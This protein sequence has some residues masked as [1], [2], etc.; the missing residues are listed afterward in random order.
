MKILFQLFIALIP[1]IFS[2]STND[3][4]LSIRFLYLSIGVSI[5]LFAHFYKK[6]KLYYNLF[7]NQF[8]ICFFLVF[9][10]CFISSLINGLTA[11]SIYFLSKIFLLIIFLLLV[12]NFLLKNSFKDFLLPILLFSFFSSIIYFYQL[13]DQYNSIVIID[14]SWHRN[15]AFDSISGSMGN[16]NLLAS[17]HFLILPFI[18]YSIRK[19][20]KFFKYFS[21]VCLFFSL[22]I[23]FQTQ[24][25]A[26]I[27]ALIISGISYLLLSKISK[28]KLFQSVKYIALIFV[29]GFLFLYSINRIDS[30][31]K[32]VTKNVDFK[33]SQRFSLYKS[34]LK[35]ISDNLIFGVGPGNWRIK[36]WEHGLYNNTFGDSFA[37]R[38]HNDFLWFFSEGGILA[39]ISYLLLFLILIRDSFWLSKNHDDSFFFKL[40]FITVLGYSFISF[41][42]FPSERISH[43]IIFLLIASIIVSSRIVVEEN[44]FFSI[45][46][47]LKFS[48]AIICLSIFYYSYNRFQSDKFAS[49]AIAFKN[50][51]NWT[52][53]IKNIDKAY[54]NLYYSVDGTSTPLHYYRGISNYYQNKIDL[55]L[56]DFKKA[57]NHNRN[58]IHVLNNLGTIHE[59]KGEYN[60]AREYY[61]KA[62]KVNPTFKEVR[63]N[64]SAI[65]YNEGKYVKALDMILESKVDV[66]WKR[67]RSNDNYDFFLKTIFSAWVKSIEDD[68]NK[69]DFNLLNKIKDNFEK[70]PAT[71]A[72]KMKE[73]FYK[74][75][76]LEN[77]YL[78]TIKENY[79]L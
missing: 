52:Q 56:I 77:G 8:F 51:G 53:T 66:Y 36:I 14:D 65:F 64:L 55:A 39:G 54:H 38:P 43:L 9:I 15:K 62:L 33:T 60:L 50:K 42:D 46:Y 29:V 61:N 59:I 20:N 58:H 41:F 78:E 76:N 45:P 40:V 27:G 11:D 12:S 57:Y 68:L 19:T 22:I 49:K 75:K 6:E 71:T 63:V 7:R 21:L 67:Q 44:K 1:L 37:Q 34:S 24:S 72:K 18:I 2:F 30:F 16:K 10:F 26:V 5:F 70:H 48:L 3:P 25:R 35:L 79:V 69:K 74:R 73:I 17:I 28:Q 23:F 47:F 4:T 31:K 32:E 13:Y